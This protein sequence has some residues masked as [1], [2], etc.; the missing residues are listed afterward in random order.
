MQRIISAFCALVFC[1]SALVA[2]AEGAMARE[3]RDRYTEM[4][5]VVADLQRIKEGKSPAG[6]HGMGRKLRHKLLRVRR[7]SIDLRI[8]WVSAC[9]V[10]MAML[11]WL[12]WPKERM[13]P[14]APPSAPASVSG[15]DRLLISTV[16]GRAGVTGSADGAGVKALSREVLNDAQSLFRVVRL[17]IRTI[18]GEGVKRICDGDNP[19]QQRNLVA[20]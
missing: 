20:L 19:R 3:L 15:Q 16:A 8:V 1:G 4:G 18:G 12:L 10:A 5:D 2:V 11:T 13:N 9:F 7:V 17:L 6:P 14:S